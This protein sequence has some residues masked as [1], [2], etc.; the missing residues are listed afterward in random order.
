MFLKEIDITIFYVTFGEHLTWAQCQSVKFIPHVGNLAK[1]QGL[2][3]NLKK[4]EEK[5]KR[6]KK[7]APSRTE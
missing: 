7:E 6:K 3:C 4:K 2:S 5:R 1:P